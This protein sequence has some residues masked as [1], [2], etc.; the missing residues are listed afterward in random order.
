MAYERGLNIDTVKPPPVFG[1]ASTKK[2]TIVQ[3]GGVGWGVAGR[4]AKRKAVK[5]KL[6][7][8]SGKRGEEAELRRRK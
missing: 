3:G 1:A 8:R 6:H 2:G 5:R 4:S 7:V